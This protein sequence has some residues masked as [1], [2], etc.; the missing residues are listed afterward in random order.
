M[1]DL[2]YQMTRRSREELVEHLNTFELDLRF[3]VGIWYFSPGGSRFHERYVPDTTIEQ[4]LELAAGWAKWGVA[5]IEAHICVY[6]TAIELVEA[7]YEVEIVADA[8]SSRT[9]ANRAIG[10]EKARDAGA[11]VTCVETALFEMLRTA[12]A[13]AFKAILNAVK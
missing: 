9:A 12:K 11:T 1:H 13:P 10:I 4:R 6:Q 7:G 8:V 5:G 2:R 3:S